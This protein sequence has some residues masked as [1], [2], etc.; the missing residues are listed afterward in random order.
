L[1]FETWDAE[2]VGEMGE[3]DG[4]GMGVPGE[5]EREWAGFLRRPLA[6]LVG[7]VWMPSDQATEI[8]RLRFLPGSGNDLKQ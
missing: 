3:E 5:R 8:Q 7:P 4:E 2:A 1:T 6:R